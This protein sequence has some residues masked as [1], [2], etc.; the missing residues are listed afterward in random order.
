MTQQTIHST[1]CVTGYTGKI[2]P[3]ASVTEPE[4]KKSMI[5]YGDG[6]NLGAYEYDHLVS[7]ELGGA[8]NDPK[9]LWPESHVLTVNGQDE[10]SFAKDKVENRLRSEVCSGKITLAVAQHAISTD[11]RTAP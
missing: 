6:T 8:A 7:L 2:R 11:W 4:K 5:A 3:P 10:G 9:N 1:I